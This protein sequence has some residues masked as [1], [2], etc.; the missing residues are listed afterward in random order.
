MRGI[1]HGLIYARS[2]YRHLAWLDE[3][4]PD[5]YIL[6]GDP[7]RV[8]AH[9]TIA[10]L[11]RKGLIRADTQK[12]KERWKRWRL[13]EHGRTSLIDYRRW[14]KPTPA[15]VVREVPEPRSKVETG[16]I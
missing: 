8:L 13:T 6:S 15:G 4:W 10:E 7:E 14:L 12:P 9:S 3:K 1:P 2:V 11:W 5:G 16:L